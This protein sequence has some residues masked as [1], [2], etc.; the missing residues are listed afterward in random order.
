MRSFWDTNFS[1]FYFPMQLG[2]FEF[3]FEFFLEI[4]G[5]V[6]RFN[7]CLFNLWIQLEFVFQ[8][9]GKRFYRAKKRERFYP[10]WE[11]P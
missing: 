8:E 1:F 3:F 6:N 9:K 2:V 4:W 10:L 5:W 7:M 11:I